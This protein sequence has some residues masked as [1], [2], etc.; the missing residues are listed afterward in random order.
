[1]KR[2]IKQNNAE[3][4]NLVFPIAPLYNP[5]GD[6][7]SDSEFKE[8]DDKSYSKQFNENTKRLIK[9]REKK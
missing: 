4:R 5:M 9:E 7:N 6:G 8:T 2:L 3:M 1:M